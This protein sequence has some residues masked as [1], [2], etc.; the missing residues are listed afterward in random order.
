MPRFSWPG[1]SSRWAYIWTIRRRRFIRQKRIANSLEIFLAASAS[2]LSPF[3]RAAEVRQKIG[4]SRIGRNLASTSSPPVTR[5]W[6]SPGKPTKSACGCW[7][8]AWKGKP[9]RFAK[10]LALPR[11]AGLFENALFLGH[12]SGISHIAAAVGARC[13]LLFGPTDPAIWAPA[14]ESVTV[15]QAP[16]GNL[17]SLTVEHVIAALQPSIVIP[18]RADGEGP[19]NCNLRLDGNSA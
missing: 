12:D 6:W 18:S 14:N 7:R 10:N 15:L 5:F 1:R 16:E 4:R 3:I 11:L 17:R 19:R 13:I 8:S 9:A 2:R